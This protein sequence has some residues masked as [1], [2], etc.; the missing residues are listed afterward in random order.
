MFMYLFPLW[1]FVVRF[2]V[3]VPNKHFSRKRTPKEILH[4]KYLFAHHRVRTDLFYSICGQCF[5]LWGENFSFDCA[6]LILP[7][8]IVIV[9]FV[10]T[11]VQLRLVQQQTLPINELDTTAVLGHPKSPA[12]IAKDKKLGHMW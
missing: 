5:F 11:L 10:F 1:L 6:E 8:I 9:I 12:R 4:K 2:N 3:S 7:T